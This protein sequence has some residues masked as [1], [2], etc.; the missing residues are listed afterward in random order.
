MILLKSFLKNIDDWIAVV[1]LAGI[2]LLTGTNVIL[3][4]LFS[5]PIAWTEEVTLML[6]VWLIFVGM[7]T[8]M[9]YNTHIGV[10]YFVEKLPKPLRIVAD[11]IRILSIYIV[12]IYVFIILGVKFIGNVSGKVTP[13]LTIN[14]QYINIA[15]IVGAVF[16]I[17]R[18]TSQVITSYKETQKGIDA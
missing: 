5:K 11:F 14:Y 4:Y 17:I 10:D 15:V 12:L 7:S 6:F 16:T 13:I 9:K 3:R 8:A 18:F 1:S 2:I